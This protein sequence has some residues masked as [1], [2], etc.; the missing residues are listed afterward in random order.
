MNATFEDVL[1]LSECMERLEPHRESV[2]AEFET[3]RKPNTDAL[4]ELAVGNFVEMRDKTGSR[5][6]RWKKKYEKLLA[7]T[8]PGWF[9]PLYVMVTF[10]RI[11]CAHAVRRA[12]R[13][14]RCV[15]AVVIALACLMVAILRW[16]T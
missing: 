6:F 11:P 5:L 15:L 9:V 12:K 10:T 4:A 7:K 1:V 13:Q 14:N 3:L 16:A 8:L 2:F